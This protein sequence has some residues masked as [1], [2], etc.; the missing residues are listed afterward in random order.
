MGKR[1]WLFV[2]VELLVEARC[3]SSVS[4][5]GGKKITFSVVLV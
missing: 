5:G 3:G 4:D 1:A 2:E